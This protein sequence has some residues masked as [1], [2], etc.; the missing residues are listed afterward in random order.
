MSRFI[1]A[2]LL[3]LSIIAPARAEGV[4]MS[5]VDAGYGRSGAQ[6]L[7]GLKVEMEDGWHSYWKSPG[8]T[9][10]PSVLSVDERENVGDAAILWP[11]P[12]RFDTSGYEIVGYRKSFIVPFTVPVEDPAKVASFRLKG[13]LYACSDVCAPFPVDLR[14]ETAPGF[15]DPSTLAEIA[16]WLRRVPSP[17][18]TSLRIISTS[19]SGEK[20]TVRFESGRMSSPSAFVDLGVRGFALLSSLTTSGGVATAEF[21]VSGPRG[22]AVDAAGAPL[23]VSDGV[24]AVSG[25]VSAA[26]LPSA[27]VLLTALLGGLVLNVMP[28]VFPVLAI[29]VFSLATVPQGRRRASYAATAFGVVSA[30][31]ALAAALAFLQAAGREVAWGMQFQQPVFLAVMAV[32]TGLFAANMAGAFEIVLPSRLATRLHAA[33][34]GQGSAAAFGQGFVLT[35]LA[36]PCS[37]PFVGS[38]IGVALSTGPAAVFPVF[39]ALGL[40]MA[41]PYI[42]LAAV[43]AAARAL[44]RPGPWMS[45]VKLLLAACMAASS[46]WLFSLVVPH[47]TASFAAFTLAAVVGG[48]ALYRRGV[49]RAAAVGCAAA[50]LTAS[51]MQLQPTFETDGVRWTKF[52]PARI[53]ELVRQGRTVFVDISA[54]WCLTCKV[55]EKGALARDETTSLLSGDVVAM[56]GDW[57]RPDEGIAGFLKA[58]GRYGIPFYLVVGPRKPEGIL[59]PELLTVEKIREAVERAS[60]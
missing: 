52:E 32:I 9:G 20:V 41:A 37:A 23:V 44:P 6:V 27:A 46:G 16:P 47:S 31:V 1:A 4:R 11:L 40:G 2:I 59:L 7:L 30:F 14:S 25:T 12:E 15:R 8:E 33:T 18:S 3:F 36:T 29:K 28:C 58:H 17:E 56:K 34:G 13:T 26:A 19:V 53:D 48:A 35:L 57:T 22:R 43:P 24:E 39:A 5:L 45:T 21:K 49:P 51:A 10:L 54:D 42:L 60:R 50:F 38:A 55:N